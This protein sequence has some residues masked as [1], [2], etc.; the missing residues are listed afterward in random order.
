MLDHGAERISAAGVPEQRAELARRYR[1]SRAIRCSSSPAGSSLSPVCTGEDWM[2]VLEGATSQWKRSDAGSAAIG[3]ASGSPA[4]I[5]TSAS[6]WR[7]TAPRSASGASARR[8]CSSSS[9]RAARKRSGRQKSTTP[10]LTHSPRSTR[11]TTRTIAYWNGLGGKPGL[12][13]LG[14]EAARPL[15]A[16]AQVLEILGSST[17]REPLV[18]HPREHL[19][20]DVPAQ[21]RREP[22]VG[23]GDVARAVQQHVVADA[24]ERTPRVGRRVLPG[25][26][27]VERGAM[28][29]Q[30]KT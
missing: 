2:I 1:T 7:C 26:L 3:P 23:L 21:A 28:V 13:G 22:G 10:A 12:L 27:E 24:G 9:T 29:D 8:R 17:R 6:R 16:A 19:L 20:D 4:A 18:R 5:R 14:G 11:G 30:P 25:M 15:Q